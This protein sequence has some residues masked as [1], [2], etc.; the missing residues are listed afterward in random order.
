MKGKLFLL[1]IIL[2]FLG[3]NFKVL[4]ME[5][6]W[7]SSPFG[8][9]LTDNSTLTDMV[10]YFYEWGIFIGGLAV[11][12]SL[13]I[14]GFLYLTS[15]GNPTRMAEAKDR[16]FSAIIGLVLLF[17][18]YLILRTIN[19]DL[20]ALGPLGPVGGIPCTKNEDCPA[21]LVCQKGICVPVGVAVTCETD[22][23]CENAGLKGYKCTQVEGF[24]NKVCVPPSGEG[25]TVRCDTDDDCPEGYECTGG[26]PD[27][28]E[29]D[30]V[31]VKT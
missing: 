6:T 27:T 8:T 26:N 25:E 5:T 11:L 10:K 14:G 12:V 9:N 22:A 18:I 24:K 1:L 30:G 4:A 29:L 28:S 2:I 23:D 7:P 31:C 16:I 17:A 20:T 21:G 3:I 15:V 19:P 13:L